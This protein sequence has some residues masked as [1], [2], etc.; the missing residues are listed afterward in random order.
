[1]EEPIE[2]TAQALIILYYKTMFDV[3]SKVEDALILEEKPSITIV[4]EHTKTYKTKST[5]PNEV[6]TFSIKV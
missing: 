6:L 4:E 2:V 1:M 3:E 5:I